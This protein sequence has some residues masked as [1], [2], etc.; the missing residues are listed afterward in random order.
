VVVGGVFS[1]FCHKDIIRDVKSVDVV[2]RGEG[3]FAL[4]ELSDALEKNRGPKQIKGLTYREGGSIKINEPRPFI[5]DLNKLPMPA[6]DLLDIKKYPNYFQGY[7]KYLFDAQRIDNIRNSIPLMFGRGCPFNC[8]FCSSKE[9][10]HRIYRILD[11]EKAVEHIKYFYDRGVRGFEFWDDH[12]ILFK[13]WFYEFSHLLKKEK[14]E[15][16][17][18]CLARVDAVDERV[19]KE[20]NKIGCMMAT[21]GLEAGSSHLLEIMRKNITLKQ[22]EDAVRMLYENRIASIGGYIIN[23]P[24]E[25]LSDITESLCF[26]K[27]LEDK[28]NKV[29]DLPTPVKIYPGTDLEKIAIKNRKLVNFKWTRPFYE[30][31]NLL[32]SSNPNVPIYENLQT[33]KLLKYV[34]KE[35]LRLKYDTVFRK[36][37]ANHII[38]LSR[39]ENYRD[40]FLDR[41]ISIK[42]FIQ[43]FSELTLKD[44]IDT[45]PYIIKSTIGHKMGL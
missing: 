19:S 30:K 12:L 1:T 3:D 13:K 40:A 31:R 5:R 23:M 16:Y 28:Y 11:P 44:Q 21:L 35:S 38:N 32:M 42:G 25:T 10:W 27:R 26:F 33:E 39:H 9:M 18:K 20:L 14:M 37:F 45:A 36:M 24:D 17:F 2:I 8:L 6:F 7:S 15:I 34:A 41:K 4:K 43:G 29:S 22:S